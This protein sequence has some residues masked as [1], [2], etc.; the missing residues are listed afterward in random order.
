M[1]TPFLVTYTIR[2]EVGNR[3]V[4]QFNIT[5]AA[6]IADAQTAA[7]A[8]IEEIESVTGGVIESPTIA[9]PLAPTLV[10]TVPLDDHFVE[11]KGLFI[12]NT[13]GGFKTRME[14]A[15]FLTSLVV[16]DSKAIDAG[17][18]PVLDVLTAV[19][20][21]APQPTPTATFTDSRDDDI[22]ANEAPTL[23]FRKNRK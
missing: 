16:E 2:D 1:A 10:R 12:F 7:E 14:I 18:G 17:P 22:V 5:S 8:L 23:V 11:Q 3:A 6:T 19:I 4:Q 21:G 15:A 20:T 9:L 13:A